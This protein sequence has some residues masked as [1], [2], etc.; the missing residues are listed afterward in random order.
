MVLDRIFIV[1][2]D[3]TIAKAVSEYLGG[4]GYE[5]VCADDFSDITAQFAKANPKLVLMDI[6]LPRYNGYHWCGE[7]RKLSQVPIIF[8]SS[9]GDNMSLVMAVNQGGD[10][11]IAKPFDMSVLVAKIKALMRR[12]YDFTKNPD[13]TEH[14]G[15]VLNSSDMTMFIGDTKTDLSKNEFRILQILF[16]NAG[17]I[18]SR[19]T[20]MRRLWETDCYVDENTLTVN[21][22][23]VRKKLSEAGIED[24]I[25]TKK[26]VGYMVE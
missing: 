11:F 25:R 23:R 16:E 4:W 15:V 12:T 6:T 20:L 2:D 1:E 22:A 24:L 21:I 14:S 9:A 8:I 26:G 19:D 3:S 10:D 13:I 7:I 5:C 18:V 17:H